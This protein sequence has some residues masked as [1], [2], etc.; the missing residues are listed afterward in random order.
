[1]NS[2]VCQ[3]PECGH[4]KL[5]HLR[6]D[7]KFGSCDFNRDGTCPCEHF[8]AK[9]DVE[10]EL[11]AA[12]GY[13]EQPTKPPSEDEV[14]KLA[15]EIWESVKGNPYL[16]K[17]EVTDAYTDVSKSW[18]RYC[19]KHEIEQTAALKAERDALQCEYE[20]RAIWIREMCAIIGHNNDDGFHCEPGPHDIAKRLVEQRDQLQSDR[21]NLHVMLAECRKENQHLLSQVAEAKRE[22]ERLKVALKQTHDICRALRYS[23]DKNMPFPSAE[24]IDEA[25]EQSSK[26]L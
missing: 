16:P 25:I 5:Q 4:T 3:N 11:R 7:G 12:H 10:K 6:L 24:S 13:P 1:M 8:Q 17:W 19:A 9:Q 15:K 2:D 20:S 18:V 22:V 23:M 26:L 14:E 21:D